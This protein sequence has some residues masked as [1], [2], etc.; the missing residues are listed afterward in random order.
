MKICYANKKTQKLCE[1]E[2]KATR[3]LGKDVA[4]S[5]MSLVNL[6]ESFPNLND[7]K[8]FPQYRLHALHQDRKHQYSFVINKRY[9]WRLIVY[10]MGDDEVILTDN[11]NET[12][13]LTKA[14]QV[15]IVEVSEHY[16]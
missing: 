8:A 10:P 9:K 16:D 11:S 1:D 12:A 3:E 2:L 14:V 5:L 7:L 4:L 13:M 6:I 15:E